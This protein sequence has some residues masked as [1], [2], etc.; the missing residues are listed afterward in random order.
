MRRDGQ[1]RAVQQ[2]LDGSVVSFTLRMERKQDAEPISLVA[3]VAYQGHSVRTGQEPAPMRSDYVNVAA[4]A[5]AWVAARKAN[6]T[7]S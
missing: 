1:S 4:R 7:A 6:C 3:R 2:S 5:D